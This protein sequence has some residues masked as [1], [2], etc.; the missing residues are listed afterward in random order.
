MAAANPRKALIIGGGDGFAARELL[1]YPQVE[2]ITNIELDKDLIGLTKNHPIMQVLTNN[3]FN[4]PKVNIMAGDGIGYLLN[5]KDKYDIIIDDCEYEYTNQGNDIK[6]IQEK[7]RYEAYRKC[8]VTKLTPGGI[9]C[10]MEPLIRVNPPKSK[11]LAY[12]IL[13]KNKLFVDPN[14]RILD[15]NRYSQKQLKESLIED[16][17]MDNSDLEFF[18]NLTPYVTYKVFMSRMIGPEAYIYFSNQPIRA[19]RKL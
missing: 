13:G 9:G 7:K 1:K 5:S 17:M 11:T 18:G 2:E 19:R 8:L 3:A 15:H 12:N 16:H 6:A 14:G 10:V 4:H